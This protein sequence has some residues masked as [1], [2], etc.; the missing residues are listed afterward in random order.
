MSGD[1]GKSFISVKPSSFNSHG[2]KIVSN[3]FTKELEEI[4]LL[5][6]SGKYHDALENTKNILES[7]EIKEKDRIHALLLQ[8][9][10]FFMLGMFEFREEY[11]QKSLELSDSAFSISNETTEFISMFEAK[12]WYLWVYFILAR[13]GIRR[14]HY[15][16]PA[17]TPKGFLERL[18][19]LRNLLNEINGK[20]IPIPEELESMYYLIQS[21]EHQLKIYTDE[22]YI[23][24]YRKT[25]EIP[26]IND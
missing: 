7:K 6:I 15:K 18:D 24:D 14:M 2:G 16:H 3:S 22:N 11:F 19:E 21:T 8:S 23:W 13:P 4:E 17:F 12:I 26:S 20:K 9:K 1:L 10:S 5:T 25:L